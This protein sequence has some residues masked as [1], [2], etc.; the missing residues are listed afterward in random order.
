[1]LHVE[2][3]V[4]ESYTVDEGMARSQDKFMLDMFLNADSFFGTVTLDVKGDISMLKISIFVLKF[5][6]CF[7]N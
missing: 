7:V 3:M 2:V 4:L 5:S 6:N 1:M